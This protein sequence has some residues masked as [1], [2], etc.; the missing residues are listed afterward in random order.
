MAGRPIG[1]EEARTG[2]ALWRQLDV[3]AARIKEQG[4]RGTSTGSARPTPNVK[5]GQ[6][7]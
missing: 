3:L 4:A 1:V 2:L 6:P 5:R 7:E